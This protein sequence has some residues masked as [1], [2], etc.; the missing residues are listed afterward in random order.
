MSGKQ[1]ALRRAGLITVGIAVGAVLVGCSQASSGS[2]ATLYN[3]LDSLAADSSVLVV[4][5][6]LTQSVEGDTTVSSVEVVN[7]PTN[8]QVGAKLGDPPM[9]VAVGET[10][11]VRQ[12]AG[13]VLQR[14]EEYLLF[15]TPTMLPGDA[16]RQ[17]FI[18]GAVAGLY[19]RHGDEFIRGV[20]DSGDDLPATI[21]VSGRTSRAG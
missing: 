4:G 20:T 5:N 11:V 10:V 18:T 1:S 17:Y 2:R 15:L 16:A 21:A 13:P 14:S 7:T 3:S 8:P 19:V 6:V 9:P 12:D